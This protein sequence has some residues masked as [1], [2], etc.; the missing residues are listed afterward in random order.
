MRSTSIVTVVA[1]ALVAVLVVDARQGSAKM[2][3]DAMV[4]SAKT[5]ADHRNLAKHYEAMAAEAR[6]KAAMHQKMAE[7]YRKEGGAIVS[8]L[9]FDEHCDALVKSFQ[10]EAEEYD[11]LAKAE[12]EMAKEMK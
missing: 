6:A 5:A 3:M 4:T 10:A 11:A 9:H 2:G 7:A 8:K 12:L 1:L